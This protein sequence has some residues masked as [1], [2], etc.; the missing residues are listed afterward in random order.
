MKK[1]NPKSPAEMEKEERIRKYLA[2]EDEPE[3][4][5]HH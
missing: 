4:E 2:G 5:H 1:M 3:P